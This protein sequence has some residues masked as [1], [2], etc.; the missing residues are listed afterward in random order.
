MLP[1][2][3]RSWRAYATVPTHWYIVAVAFMALQTHASSSAT[4]FITD[5]YG[6]LMNFSQSTG[7]MF[8]GFSREDENKLLSGEQRIHRIFP[9]D[10][11]I[12]L[13]RTRKLTF[14]KPKLWKD[15]YENLMNR[16]IQMDDGRTIRVP[17]Y[18]DDLFAQC[19]SLEYESDA[20]WRIYSGDERGVLVSANA[21]T[22]YRTAE[23]TYPWPTEQLFLG[24]VEYLSEHALKQK[25][26]SHEFLRSV[27]KSGMYSSGVAQTL[28]Y[29]RDSFKHEAEVRWIISRH[30][31]NI[32]GDVHHLPINLEASI[33]KVTL[34][35]RLSDEDM[36]RQIFLI[37]SAGYSGEVV[38]S[39]LYGMP[40]LSLAIPSLDWLHGLSP[41]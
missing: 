35:P 33:T 38:Q 22:L 21:A 28:L 18:E 4:V 23:S 13:V 10:R 27:L 26:E 20:M 17:H 34:D 11:F 8:L 5:Y 16:P 41:S 37:R 31:S 30:I 32:P 7:P 1:V 12:D 6:A 29:K 3:Y 40:E 2:L 24:K 15:P 39:S 14:V 19:W 9:F 36:E 25:F